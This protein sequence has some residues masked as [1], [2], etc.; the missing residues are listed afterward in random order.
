[1]DMFLIKSYTKYN[2][3]TEVELINPTTGLTKTILIELSHPEFMEELVEILS[4]YSHRCK[5]YFK[6]ELDKWII[7]VR[8]KKHKEV[9]YFEQHIVQTAAIQS[10]TL[11]YLDYFDLPLSLEN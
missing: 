10:N 9:H 3:Y 8:D 4:W 11:L 5:I 7:M 1:M 2:E 6:F